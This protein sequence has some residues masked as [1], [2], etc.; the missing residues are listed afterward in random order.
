[1]GAPADV[2]ANGAPPLACD[3]DCA[4]TFVPFYA[5]C[6]ELLSTYFDSID[7]IEDHAAKAIDGMN[8]RCQTLEQNKIVTTMVLL[9][10]AGCTV[11]TAGIV[12]EMD[13]KTGRRALQLGYSGADTCSFASFD[14][15]V[16]EINTN[17][18]DDS[19]ED[20]NCQAGIPNSCDFECA[21]VWK[22]FVTECA[23][24]IA[25]AMPGM[26][27]GKFVVVTATCDALPQSL[28]MAAIRNSVAACDCP[29]PPALT[30]TGALMCNEP[31]GAEGQH[32]SSMS[33]QLWMHLKTEPTCPLTMFARR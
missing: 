14:S 4:A 13:V 6:S 30:V 21:A 33:P 7:E 8:D 16:A 5:D 15:R 2:C 26:M 10:D 17:C 32:P 18:C 11:E 19:D 22:K 25:V 24:L 23:T 31:G 29:V 12:A 3:I 27:E 20:D 28:M 1:V 9:Q